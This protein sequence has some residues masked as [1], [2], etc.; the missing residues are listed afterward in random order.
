MFSRAQV[1]GLIRPQPCWSGFDDFI[2]KFY[3]VPASWGLANLR[4]CWA[5]RDT[6]LKIG[7]TKLQAS[8]AAQDNTTQVIMAIADSLDERPI[9]VPVFRHQDLKTRWPDAYPGESNV[10]DDALIV[11]DGNKRLTALAVRLVRRQPILV[12]CLGLFVGDLRLPKGIG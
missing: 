2:Y 5:E 11:E 9:L 3:I 4:T 8:T 10:P 7:A 6:F 1:T 12:D